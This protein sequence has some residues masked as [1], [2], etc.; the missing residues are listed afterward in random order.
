[1]STNDPSPKSVVH[2]SSDDSRTTVYMKT[3]HQTVW[4]KQPNKITHFFY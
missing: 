4:V 1:M 3:S 2:E